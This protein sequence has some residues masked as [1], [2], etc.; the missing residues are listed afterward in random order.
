MAASLQPLRLVATRSSRCGEL[1]CVLRALSNIS[2]PHTILGVKK[3]ATKTDIKAAFHERAKHGKYRHPDH[4]GTAASF[5]ELMDAKA[6]M[7]NGYEPE[8]SSS[9]RPKK[10][11]QQSS[12]K[13]KQAKHANAEDERKREAQSEADRRRHNLSEVKRLADIVRKREEQARRQDIQKRKAKWAQ[14]ATSPTADP[15]MEQK[16]KQRREHDR[17]VKQ[18]QT[19]LKWAQLLVDDATRDSAINHLHQLDQRIVELKVIVLTL[20]MT[21]PRSIRRETLCPRCSRTLS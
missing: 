12:Q 15:E 8:A 14:K 11:K 3:G 19:T 21:L 6:V 13:P 4:G 7:I 17:L 1:S 18:H 9:T 20:F 10:A 16:L 2:R 5:L